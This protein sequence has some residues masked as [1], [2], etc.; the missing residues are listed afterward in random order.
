MYDGITPSLNVW[1]A[2]VYL[3]ARG[4][5][6]S[7]ILPGGKRKIGCVVPISVRQDFE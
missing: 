7:D 1:Q 5:L 2:A 4:A 3:P 6:G